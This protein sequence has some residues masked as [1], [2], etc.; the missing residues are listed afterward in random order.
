MALTY[1]K[2][3]NNHAAYSS[4]KEILDSSIG[5]ALK[6]NIS[7]CD[8]DEHL[9]FN[10]VLAVKMTSLETGDNTEISISARKL[11]NGKLTWDN[12]TKSGIVDYMGIDI[13]NYKH[14]KITVYDTVTELDPTQGL[15]SPPA[16]FML[17]VGLTE[18]TLPDTISVIPD[19]L[20]WG[21]LDLTTVKLGSGVTRID[22]G[23]FDQC[24]ELVNFICMAETPP[25]NTNGGMPTSHSNFDIYVPDNSVDAYKAAQGWSRYA[26][27]IYPIS[28]YQG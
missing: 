14:A 25:D 1:N 5:E 28:N 18:L 12:I 3:F 8:S 4:Y 10:P 17:L 20:C 2:F 26:A 24:S 21:C 13:N 19:S 11:N 23:A 7:L 22:Y 15:Y 9:H 27:R 16:T 6:D